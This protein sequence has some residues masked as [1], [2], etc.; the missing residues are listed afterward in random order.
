MLT[1]LE[2]SLHIEAVGGAGL[3]VGGTLQVVG[4]LP[5]ASVI[6]DSGVGGADGILRGQN[7]SL[8]GIGIGKHSRYFY[9]NKDKDTCEDNITV[10]A[11]L[12]RKIQLYTVE[13]P[14]F[15]SSALINTIYSMC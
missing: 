6:N 4:E 3:V 13:L 5:G 8:F 15:C 14:Q 7:D 12:F 1:V 2:D 11:Y 10:P 9:F